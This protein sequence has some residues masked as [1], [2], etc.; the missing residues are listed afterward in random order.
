M[1]VQCLNGIGLVL[2]YTDGGTFCAQLATYNFCPAQHRLGTLQHQAVVIGQVGLALGAIDQQLGD[3]LAFRDG[4]F[5]MGGEGG[6]T[7]ADNACIL[8]RV[9]ELLNGERLPVDAEGGGKLLGSVGIGLYLNGRFEAAIDV[10][11]RADLAYG[12]GNRA[13]Q[14]GGDKGPRFCDQLA[15]LDPFTC[16]DHRF[17]RCPDVLAQRYHVA[18]DKGYPLDRQIIGLLLVVG[19]MDPVLEAMA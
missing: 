8:D 13:V 7:H 2:L 14:G 9:D 1:T 12:A 4:V 18:F 11:A 3:L 19:R 16:L 6:T 15:T 17:G 10:T 5:D